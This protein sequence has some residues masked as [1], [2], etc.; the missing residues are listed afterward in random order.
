[1]RFSMLSCLALC[2]FCP[3]FLAAADRIE[4]VAGAAKGDL[5]LPFGVVLDRQ[6]NVLIVEYGGHRVRKLDAAGKLTTLAGTGKKG[7]A[8]DGGPALQAELNFMHSLALAASGDLYLADTLNHRVRRINR[9]GTVA[10]FAGTGK[11]GFSGD[12]G[13]A[14]RAEFNGI[15]CIAFA[16]REVRLLVVD[17]ENRRVRAVDMESGVV[18]T[19][20]GNGKRGVPADGA[21]A[22]SS[23]LVDPRAVAVDSQGNVYILE[24]SGHALR[25]VDPKGK[26]RTVAGTGK[27]GYGGDGGPALQAQLRHSEVPAARRQDRPCG[28]D[29]QGRPCRRRRPAARM[30]AQA[31]ARSLRLG[32]GRPLHRRQRQQPG[33]ARQ[34]RL[35]RDGRCRREERA[36]AGL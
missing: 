30:S 31:A 1:M 10:T 6:G 35:N 4:L 23:P 19:V 29:R 28:R 27:A 32:Q 12:G 26:I 33:A 24:R 5:N 25:L 9:E 17:L 14:T 18:R 2:L 7:D 36:G 15:Y 3:P 8:G 16:H 34:T 20:A 11:A 21:D 22:R 13:P